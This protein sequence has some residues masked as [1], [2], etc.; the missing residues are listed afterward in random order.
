MEWLN[1]H[2]LLYFWT[3][4]REGG[5]SKAA[6]TLRLAQPT[7]S[8]Q[9]KMLEESVGERLFERQG[10]RLVLTGPG[11]QLLADCRNILGAV[12]SLGERARLLRREDTGVLKVGAT[13]QMIDGVFATFE[14]PTEAIR[15]ALALTEAV[16]ELGIEIRAG[17]HFGET[18]RIGE[19]LG[20]IAVHTGARV[21]SV[22]GPGE[23]LVTAATRDLVAGS[24][25]TFD[26]HGVHELKGIDGAQHIGIGSQVAQ[27]RKAEAGHKPV[28]IGEG[29]RE[30]LAGVEEQH[31]G[32]RGH[33]G[34]QR[35]R[36]RRL[37]AE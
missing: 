29:F 8:A 14:R 12:E 27:A 9:V 11:E 37:R 28:A 36:H 7:V 17:V 31:R 22:G 34:D 16:R 19:K 24:G 18:E 33:L 10:R 3:V 1:Y 21:M 35:Q 13:P 15:C 5:V 20:G 4:A 25:F 6:E 32:F 30:M 2:H 26:D 23:V